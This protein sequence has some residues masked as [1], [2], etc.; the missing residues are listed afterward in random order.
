[1]RLLRHL[2]EKPWLAAQGR[3]DDLDDGV[4]FSLPKAELALRVFM[5]MVT[6]LFTL[7]VVAYGERMVHEDWR[8][9]PPLRLLWLN[10]AM[11]VLGSAAFQWATVAVRRAERSSLSRRR[12]MEH[13][14]WAL[15][16]AGVFTSAFLGG[17]IVAWWQLNLVPFFDITHPAIA[18]FCLITGLHALHMLGGLAAWGTTTAKMSDDVDLSR[19]HQSIRLCAIYWHFLLAVWLVLFGLLFSGNDNLSTLLAICGLK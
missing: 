19:L 1:M 13:V 2:T 11:L 15:S 8:P 10:T 16:A 9:A 14:K 18:F 17:Q 4:A 5:A 7:L 6:V 12:E 3:I